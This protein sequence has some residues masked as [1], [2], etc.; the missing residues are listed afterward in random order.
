MVWY[1][2]PVLEASFMGAESA[3]IE[4]SCSEII[5]KKIKENYYVIIRDR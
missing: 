2:T 5:K 3:V 4:R 1:H